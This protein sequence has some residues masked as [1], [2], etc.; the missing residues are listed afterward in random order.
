M[1]L[2][3]FAADTLKE[4]YFGKL[5]TTSR[6][7]FER[8]RQISVYKLEIIGRFPEI[9][10]FLMAA[11]FEE[12]GEVRHDILK[13]DNE[14][15]QGGYGKVYENIDYSLFKEG[16]DI[17][18]A[19]EIIAWTTEGFA[20]KEQVKLKHSRDLERDYNEILAGFAPYLDILKKSFYK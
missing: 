18:K 16:V 3:D 13:R 5:D 20:M 14:Q 15:L 12:S 1:F 6:D 8:L 10:N 19:M 11:H 4:D 9:Y 7:I 17:G 2:Y